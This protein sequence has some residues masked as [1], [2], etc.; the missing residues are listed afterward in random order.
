MGKQIYHGLTVA[1][2]R[3][4]FNPNLRT[5]IRGEKKLALLTIGVR[6]SVRRAS[7]GPCSVLLA[8]IKKIPTSPPPFFFSLLT[9]D[10]QKEKLKIKMSR[11]KFLKNLIAIN[12][13]KLFQKNPRFLY[14]VQVCP[15][16]FKERCFKILPSYLAFSQIWLKSLF[17]T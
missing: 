13:T 1:I 9:I 4:F 14:F 11:I 3:P 2:P 5:L 10:S 15:Q 16:K 7:I 17:H 12:S 6:K 8:P